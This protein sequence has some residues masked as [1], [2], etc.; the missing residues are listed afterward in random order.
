MVGIFLVRYVTE[1]DKFRVG[2]KK[3]LARRNAVSG[4]AVRVMAECRLM[5]PRADRPHHDREGFSFREGFSLNKMKILRDHEPE[6][7]RCRTNQTN[8]TVAASANQR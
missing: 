3:V 7:P 4:Y 5:P 8:G 6:L 1:P 2:I